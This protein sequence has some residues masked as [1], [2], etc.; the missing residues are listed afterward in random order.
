MDTTN[1]IKENAAM[2]SKFDEH[3]QGV[4]SFISKVN[5]I[6]FM[7]ILMKT[8]LQHK[9]RD[10]YGEGLSEEDL[11]VLTHSDQSIVLWHL[12]MYLG[13]K[14]DSRVEKIFKK[15]FGDFREYHCDDELDA[16]LLVF[17]NLMDLDLKEFRH[18]SPMVDEMEISPK[19]LN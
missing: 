14:M 3:H 9:C 16:L 7:N 8:L 4:L 5:S 6:W 15:I 10:I 17:Y 1:L 19:E 11:K 2:L 18:H 13:A 12:A